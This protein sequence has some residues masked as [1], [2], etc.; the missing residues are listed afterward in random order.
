[1]E[2]LLDLYAEDF[3]PLRPVV[4]FDEL[5]YQL[6]AETRLPLPL[7]PGKPLRYDYEYR[8]NGT[9]NLFVFFQPLAGWR[10]VEV[11]EQRT[12]RDFAYR[13][14][15]LVDVHFPQAEV[16]RMVLDNLNTHSPAAL[17]EVFEP[18]E[19]RRIVRKLEFHYTP[20]HGSWLNMAEIEISVLERQCL[21]RRLAEAPMVR[22]EVLA[23]ETLRNDQHASVDWRFTT[24]K[25]RSKMQFLYPSKS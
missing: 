19:A 13:M 15:D 24:A 4:C 3:D 25:A 16:I 20:L 1:M 18:Q 8:R 23:W 9:C 2:D 11:T 17:Y 12:K 21:D 5:P 10:H 22:S 7:Q 14:K 6:V